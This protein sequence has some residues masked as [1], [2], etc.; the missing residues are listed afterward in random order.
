MASLAARNQQ[1]QAAVSLEAARVSPPVVA[2][3]AEAANQQ[4]LA[5]AASLEVAKVP[6][7]SDHQARR[8]EE[9]SLAAV[10]AK[11]QQVSGG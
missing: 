1:A 3:L 11:L 9:D 10:A 8:P 5:V 6:A 7:D 2:C 4:E